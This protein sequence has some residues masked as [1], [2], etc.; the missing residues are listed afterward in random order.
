MLS[1]ELQQTIIKL[2]PIDKIH[3][4]EVLLNSLDKP[5]SSIEKLWIKESEARYQAY[6]DGEMEAKPLDEVITDLLK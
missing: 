5:D 3:L 2:K 1:N 4:I 6:K